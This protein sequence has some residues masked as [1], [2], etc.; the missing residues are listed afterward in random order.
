MNMWAGQRAVNRFDKIPVVE[1]MPGLIYVGGATGNGIMKCD[2][3]GRIVAANYSGE[4][5]AELFGGRS[6]R[7]SD[8]SVKDRRVEKERF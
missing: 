6:V 8:I 1:R 3:L 2:S 7:V 5:E 4:K